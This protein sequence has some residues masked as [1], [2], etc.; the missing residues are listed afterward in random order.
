MYWRYRDER[1]AA[2]RAGDEVTPEYRADAVVRTIL[3]AGRAVVFS[4]FAVAIGLAL[5]LLMPLP[6][7]QGFGVAGLVIPIISII[8]ALTLLPALLYSAAHHLE[9]VRFLPK[10]LMERRD[11]MDSSY[12]ARLA[13]FIMRR[14]WP[15][16]IVSS[17]ALLFLAWPVQHLRVTPGSSV[18]IPKSVE[19]VAGIKLM[20]DIM[21]RGAGTPTVVL[22]D[23][24][25]PGGAKA[26]NVQAAGV[27]IAKL[28]A[29]DKE[30]KSVTQPNIDTAF[31][32]TN[33]FLKI[34][35]IGKNEYGEKPSRDFVQR[36]RDT[37]VSKAEFPNNA[38]VLV[39]G[40]PA[41]GVDLIDKTY[42]AFPWLVAG[43]LALT[44]ILL[45]R[46]FRSILLP[47]KAI[48]LNL[49]SIGA[50]YG[51]LV[52]VFDSNFA[53]KIGLTSYGPIEFWIPVFLFA[54]LFGLSM[55]Y[56]VF[57]V[58]RMREIWD[59]THDNHKAV[60]LGLAR[61]GRLVTAAGIIMVTAFG[62]FMLSRPVGFQQFGLGL[63]AAIFIDITLVRALL[64]PSAM[65][66]F[67][68]WNWWLPAWIAR[69]A[70][71]KPSP[72]EPKAHA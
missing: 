29:T 63:S 39:G 40:S 27:R 23:T 44:Y 1:V 12:W 10:S 72:L 54:M 69:I 31:D 66:L 47:A 50:A 21:G 61:T 33:R 42:D 37:Y 53:D 26:S 8:A 4:G 28:M 59:E 34:D 49:L 70:I 58:S 24:H 56:E 68:R 16:F 15:V 48:V 6:F 55:D 18:G 71:V 14:P 19:S 2:V 41:V 36:V 17:A 32:Q 25:K 11:N 43:V 3:T 22:V 52:R 46:A 64:L 57:L 35:A 67:G 60:T 38:E 30:I 13:G 62:G 5:L 20:N 45:L 51:L 65:T 9:T 7:M